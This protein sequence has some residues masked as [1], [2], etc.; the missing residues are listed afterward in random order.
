MKNKRGWIKI[1]EAFASI[2]LIAGALI[3]IIN[4]L[5][6]KIPDSSLLVYDSEYAILREI[7]LDNNLRSDILAA[8]ISIGGSDAPQD[9]KD[10]IEDRKPAYLECE[11]KLCKINDVCGSSS[12]I[13][14]DRDIFVQSA[15]FGANQADYAKRKLNLFCWIEG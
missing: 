11:A 13:P 12:T 15:F 9:V 3:V 1:V 6:L 14:N 4:S 5:G 8:T 7:Q 2:L 10:K